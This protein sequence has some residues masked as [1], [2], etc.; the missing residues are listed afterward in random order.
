MDRDAFVMRLCSMVAA[1]SPPSKRV[2]VCATRLFSGCCFEYFVSDE[3]IRHMVRDAFVWRFGV[4][5]AR[6][7]VKD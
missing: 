7:T 4:D 5:G 2:R 1:G 6:P 3:Q